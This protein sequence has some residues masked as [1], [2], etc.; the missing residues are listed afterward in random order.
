MP[1]KN[2]FK[3]LNEQMLNEQD[4]NQ[5]KDPWTTPPQNEQARHNRMHFT[6]CYDDDCWAHRQA[7][8]GANYFP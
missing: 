3:D 2:E 8:E 7:K 4:L 6:A 5:D 1:D